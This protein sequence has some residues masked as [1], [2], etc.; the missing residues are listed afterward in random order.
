MLCAATSVTSLPCH[1][2]TYKALANDDLCT[3]CYE[4]KVKLFT[5]KLAYQNNSTNMSGTERAL[6]IRFD[7]AA[8][9]LYDVHEYAQN[10]ELAN[11]IFVGNLLLSS[12]LCVAAL[13]CEYGKYFQFIAIKEYNY[14]NK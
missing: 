9:R 1:T 8:L 13:H 7:C 4:Q 5:L 6:S 3:L 2:H 14:F 11:M 10:R 12:C